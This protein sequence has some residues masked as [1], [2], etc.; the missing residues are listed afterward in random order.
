VA[1]LPFSGP[2]AFGQSATTP[3][4]NGS[5]VTPANPLPVVQTQPPPPGPVFVMPAPPQLS[6]WRLDCMCFKANP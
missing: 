5:A 1:M 2:P 4:V 3:W 6:R